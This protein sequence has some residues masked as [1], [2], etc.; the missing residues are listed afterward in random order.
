M[1]QVRARDPEA[2]SGDIEEEREGNVWM[3]KERVRPIVLVKWKRYNPPSKALAAAKREGDPLNWVRLAHDWYEDEV[4]IALPPEQRMVWPALVAR[5][6]RGDPH[7][8]IRATPQDLAAKFRLPI[9]CVEAAL[10]H[11]WRKGLVRYS[12]TKKDAEGGE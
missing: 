9:E 1:A 12:M 6:G 4:L 5:A 11:F 2:R 3:P 10:D 7:G 8:V